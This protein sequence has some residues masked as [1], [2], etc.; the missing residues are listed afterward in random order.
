[1]KFLYEYRTSDNVKHSGVIK[2]A[3]REAAYLILKKQGIKPSRFSEAP[4]L[5]NKLFGKGKRWIAIGVLAVVAVVAVFQA[6]RA[7]REVERVIRG[8]ETAERH[9]IYG[10][11]VVIEEME[12]AGYARVFA[13]P[14]ERF[15]ASFAQ[16]GREVLTPEKC[17]PSIVAA[18]LTNVIVFSSDDV[19][20]VAELKRIVNGIK[21]EMRTYLAEGSAS[22]FVRALW[23][24]QREEHM[25]YVRV[26]NELEGDPDPEIR[27][28]RN[29]AL[30]ELGLRTVPRAGRMSEKNPDFPR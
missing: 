21:E 10:D 18:C 30:R 4:G 2:A 26:L 8:E 28:E 6:L 19:R 15:L 24:R 23:E 25:I 12:S 13:H 29:R 3:D 5:F 20:E 16:P 17:D 22:D 14:G 9:Q 7:E 11:P 27:E 1:M